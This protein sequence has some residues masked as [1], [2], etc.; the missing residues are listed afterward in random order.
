MLRRLDWRPGS[1][2]ACR[3]RKLIWYDAVRYRR[4]HTTP[5][6]HGTS[7]RIFKVSLV[8]PC[9]STLGDLSF[10]YPIF[11]NYSPGKIHKTCVSSRRKVF[12]GFCSSLRTC[13]SSRRK[14]PPDDY[15][16]LH[17][18]KVSKKNVGAGESFSPSRCGCHQR[19]HPKRTSILR[20]CEQ[21]GGTSA[22]V[23]SHQIPGAVSTRTRRDRT[24]NRNASRLGPLD[25]LSSRF[26]HAFFRLTVR[27][28]MIYRQMIYRQRAEKPADIGR[29]CWVQSQD[30][31]RLKWAQVL[32]PNWL[33]RQSIFAELWALN[34]LRCCQPCTWLDWHV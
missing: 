5:S 8:D 31:T 10:N 18:H 1:G 3:F 16:H 9:P 27:S 11:R 24:V 33:D 21:D 12:D 32:Q 22:L 34:F 14:H 13:F 26:S 20:I 6:W 7:S 30:P 29:P 25:Q 4:N 28:P 19:T 23:W 2:S 15:T 17:S